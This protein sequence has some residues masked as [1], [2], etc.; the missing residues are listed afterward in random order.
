MTFFK[1]FALLTRQ[2][3][4]FGKQLISSQL[5]SSRNLSSKSIHVSNYD[6][7]TLQVS[8]P[9]EH[10]L[11]VELNRCDAKNA[12]NKEMFRELYELFCRIN[13]DQHCRAVVLSGTG[14]QFSVGLDYNDMIEMVSQIRGT[15]S[16]TAGM[17]DVARKAKYIRSMILL[18]Q[19]SF[20]VLEQCSKPIIAAI[21]GPC[22]GSAL[23][24]VSAA[25]IRYASEDAY[26]H[27]KEIDTGRAPDM[28]GL[29]RIPRIS[30]NDSYI[31]EMIYTAR[32][33][34][35]SEAK[36]MGMVSKLFAD[37]E[38]TKKAAIET[39]TLI[40]TKSPVAVQGSKICMRYS[41]EHNTQDGLT[42]MANWN[43]AMLQSEDVS[44]AA[45]GW[46]KDSTEVPT[47]SDL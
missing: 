44:N 43:M 19:D 20:T 15:S 38:Q 28:G 26:F 16:R 5:I 7:D 22:V 47:F 27:V 14:K 13:D 34:P 9:C 1:T 11:H 8:S 24:L 23:G 18:F 39:A 21:H 17:S 30:G 29:Q 10:V 42:L 36:E 32:K 46:R 12:L 45:K 31:R 33:V 37:G 6:Y 25:D 2:S 40:S 41:R 4:N 3:A 35:A